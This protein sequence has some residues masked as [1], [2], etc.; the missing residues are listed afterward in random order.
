MKLLRVKKNWVKDFNTAKTN[1]EE[2][3][4]LYEFFKE[5]ETT[6]QEVTSQYEKLN[7]HLEDLEFKNM[8][9]EEGDNLSAVLQI[10]AGAGG[11]ESCDWASML[12]RMYLMLSLIHI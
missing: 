7:N 2:L 10:T 5:G 9:S 6:E 4:I 12:M 1:L 8:L 3:E 11:T